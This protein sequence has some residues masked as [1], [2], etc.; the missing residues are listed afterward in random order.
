MNM[1]LLIIL[2]YLSITLAIGI[3]LHRRTKRNSVDFFLA[4]RSLSNLL[5]F[6]TMAASNFSAFTI[7][8]LSGAGY[9][10]G[11]AFYPVMGFG[12]GFM[13]L[14]MYLVGRKIIPLAR[15]RE[16][17][18]PSDF[19]ADRYGSQSLKKVSS[20]VMIVFTLPYLA[21]QAIAAGN[22]LHSLTGISYAGGAFLITS[23]VMIYVVLGGLRTIAWTDFLQGVM[24][25]TFAA[26]AFA[27]IAEK[28]GGF[29]AVNERLLSETPALFSRPGADGSMTRGVWFGYTFLWFFSVPFTP[30]LF[31]R[32][33]A[34]KS[35]KHFST[36]VVL[37]PIITTILFFL[38]VSIGVLGRASFPGLPAG[39]SDTIFP[40]LLGRFTGV[41]T[42]TLL[43]TGSIAALMSTMDSQL[44]TLT[45]IISLD[46]NLFG[47]EMPERKRVAWEK[48]I[49]VLLGGAGFLIALRPPETLLAFVQATTFNGISVLAPL[50]LGGL[51]WHRA[52]KWG[53]FASLAGGELLVVLYYFDLLP[54]FGTLPAVPIVA[55]TSLLFIGVS[56]AVSRT[57][58]KSPKFRVKPGPN[59]SGFAERL[60]TERLPGFAVFSLIAIFIVSNDF[61]AWGKT[62]VLFW[63]LPLWVWYFAGLGILLAAAFRLT[64]HRI[65]PIRLSGKEK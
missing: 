19:I 47:D 64:L 35:E 65:I 6:F 23:F 45:S 42:S 28:S 46:F 11:Y 24:M 16:Y 56:L 36:T 58:E 10:I 30:H 52:N 3:G 62:P 5:L 9:R 54:A 53:A 20:I 31:Q 33:L 13:A 40:L 34:A 49:V 41:F 38:T 37:Y 2:G 59:T 57:I 12:T 39:E 14:S 51:Y 18:T 27:I 17:V 22:S 4:G 32:F 8:G 63:G 21:L 50:V 61:W 1:R 15:E 29:A 25:I 60:R 44:L 7:F 55:V 48:L 26:I 43:L